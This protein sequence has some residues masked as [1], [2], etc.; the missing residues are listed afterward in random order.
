MQGLADEYPTTFK[1][2]GALR[3]Q[4][5]PVLVS[6]GVAKEWF[7]YHCDDLKYIGNKGALEKLC[8]ST[9][10]EGRYFR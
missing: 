1:L 2:C 10:R 3:K 6:A 7:K 5:P 8:V 4:S 9:I